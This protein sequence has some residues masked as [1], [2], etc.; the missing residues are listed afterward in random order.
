MDRFGILFF[1]V[2]LW[3]NELFVQKDEKPEIVLTI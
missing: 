3:I 1:F 2:L